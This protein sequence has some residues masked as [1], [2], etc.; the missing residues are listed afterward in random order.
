MPSSNCTASRTSPYTSSTSGA[1]ST[2]GTPPDRHSSSDTHTA[3]PA[4]PPSSVTVIIHKPNE[5]DPG[6][7]PNVCGVV[8]VTPVHH[9]RQPLGNRRHRVRHIEVRRQRLRTVHHQ[10]PDRA[11]RRPPRPPASQDH[12]SNSQRHNP[13]SPEPSSPS[14]PDSPHTSSGLPPPPS[15]RDST[16]TSPPRTGFTASRHRMLRPERHRIRRRRLRAPSPYGSEPPDHSNPD[17]DTASPSH[18]AAETSP[19]SYA[20]SPEAS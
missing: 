6:A 10:R 16:S 20:P 7:H 18:P 12:P 5:R 19:R 13:H 9:H 4:H 8:Y 14:P 15:P 2:S 17:T 11:A 1:S 3:S